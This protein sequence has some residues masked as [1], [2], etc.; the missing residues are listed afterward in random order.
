MRMPQQ[1]PF[2]ERGERESGGMRWDFVPVQGRIGRRGRHGCDGAS[3]ADSRRLRLRLRLRPVGVRLAP[4]APRS[5]NA[6]LRSLDRVKGRADIEEEHG[7]IRGG[8]VGRGVVV[9]HIAHFFALA[10]VGNAISC[11]C[12]SPHHPVVAIKR[13]LRAG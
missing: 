8:V 7:L 5:P 1:P 6:S 12:G 2:R 3:H 11:G 4:L 9:D 10:I 13:R